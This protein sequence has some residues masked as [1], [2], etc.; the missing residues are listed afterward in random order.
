MEGGNRSRKKPEG[1]EIFFS[2]PWPPTKNIFFILAVTDR[3]NTMRGISGKKRLVLGAVS[4]GFPYKAVRRTGP[5]RPQADHNPQHIRRDGVRVRCLAGSH[6][7]QFPGDRSEAE[8]EG[9]GRPFAG[10]PPL[11][12]NTPFI[13]TESLEIKRK[14]TA[15]SREALLT[16]LDQLRHLNKNLRLDQ[17]IINFCYKLL[18]TVFNSF[19][20]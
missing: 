6:R 2:R 3:S 5:N 17:D 1:L 8:P 16:D 7:G 18:L 19:K 12:R 15:S 4:Q 9:T 11:K 10:T 13:Q 20:L 14:F